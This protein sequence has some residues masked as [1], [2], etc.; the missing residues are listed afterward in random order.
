V[1][2]EKRIAA[3]IACGGG[4]ACVLTKEV[5]RRTQENPNPLRK[6]TASECWSWKWLAR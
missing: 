5:W 6:T 2:E 4:G 3:G 1:G